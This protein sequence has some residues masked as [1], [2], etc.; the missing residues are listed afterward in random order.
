[1]ATLS[2]FMCEDS[3]GS[4]AGVVSAADAFDVWVAVVVVGGVVVDVVV[5]VVVT[6]AF[7]VLVLIDTVS[8]G[9]RST[10]VM[11]ILI[12]LKYRK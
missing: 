7:A 5:V 1:M 12:S 9:D 11:K 10:T 2:V 4:E 6:V 3:A 8:P